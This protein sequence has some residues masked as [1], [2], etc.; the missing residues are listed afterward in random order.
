MATATL[1]NAP[2]NTVA[3]AITGTEEAGETLTCS[4]GTWTGEAPISYAYQWYRTG[5]GAIGGATSSTYDLTNLDAG[6]TIYCIVT[7]SNT[8][9]GTPYENTAQSN[10]TGTIVGDPINSFDDISGIVAHYA[11]SSIQ[12]SGSNVTGW[13]DLSG[14]GY[15]ATTS[16]GNPILGTLNGIQAVDFRSA[17]PDVLEI[18]A[19]GFRS[20]PAG[21][22]TLIIIFQADDITKN[23]SLLNKG[24]GGGGY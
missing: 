12:T 21:D 15:H 7:A 10:T 22:N 13:N 6:F 11:S 14:N 5:I 9:L 18:S 19:T 3:P 1:P 20:I 17:N 16:S 23:Q 4:S 24:Q 2:Q 8:S